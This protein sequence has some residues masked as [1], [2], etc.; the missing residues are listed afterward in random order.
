MSNAPAKLASASAQ[1]LACRNTLAAATCHM[2]SI[3]N[4]V[5]ESFLVNSLNV[6]MSRHPQSLPLRLLRLCSENP[7]VDQYIKPLYTQG[8]YSGIRGV[9][10]TTPC[11]SNL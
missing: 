11:A 1:L 5:S 8:M 4:I 2:T 7:A 9:S 3:Q 6:D 10:M